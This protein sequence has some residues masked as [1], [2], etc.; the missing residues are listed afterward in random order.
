MRSPSVSSVLLSP[1]VGNTPLCEEFHTA[2]VAEFISQQSVISGK[3]LL[4]FDV[5]SLAVYQCAS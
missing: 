2:K 4:S 3:I 1:L 5:V